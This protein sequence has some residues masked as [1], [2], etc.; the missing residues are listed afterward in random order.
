MRTLLFFKRQN[1][2][3]KLDIRKI[4]N[5]L[6]ISKIKSFDPIGL[7]LDK[8]GLDTK[9]LNLYIVEK[10][11]ILKILIPIS[12]PLVYVYYVQT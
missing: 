4:K 8:K 3:E 6:G 1:K 11:R 5:L 10:G 2:K 9:G 7:V 12:G